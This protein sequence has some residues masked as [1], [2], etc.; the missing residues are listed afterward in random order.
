MAFV[1]PVNE[2]NF[3]E[4]VLKADKLVLIDFYADW[5]GPCKGLA[6]V[7]EKFAEENQD[8]VK[9]VK[10]NVDENPKLSEKFNIRTVPTLVTMKGDKGIYMA[11]GALPK[12]A[13]ERFVDDS[14]QLLRQNNIN[15]KPSD[16]GPTP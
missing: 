3:E 7:L 15:Q 1:I 10:I 14:L 16:K 2:N 9:V 5:C 12:E 4:E 6:P 13:I 8:K 11:T